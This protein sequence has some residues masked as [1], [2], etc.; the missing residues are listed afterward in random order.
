M[1]PFSRWRELWGK[2]LRRVRKEESQRSRRITNLRSNSQCPISV[3]TYFMASVTERSK[4]NKQRKV[5]YLRLVLFLWFSSPTRRLDYH[6][7]LHRWQRN[8]GK[9]KKKPA[10]QPTKNNPLK[11]TCKQTEK[12]EIA[13]YFFICLPAIT[14]MFSLF[15]TKSLMCI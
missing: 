13:V 14:D 8:N 5:L 7:H 9:K 12:E 1:V 3:S 6:H 15:I 10:K 4:K 2:L 11:K